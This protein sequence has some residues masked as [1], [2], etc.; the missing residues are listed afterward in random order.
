MNVED[1]IFKVA[2]GAPGFLLAVVCHEAAHAYVAY[3]YGDDTA[4]RQGRLTLNPVAHFDLIGTILFPLLGAMFS[5]FMFGW[6]KPVPINPARF[7]KVRQ[8]I[9]WVSFAGPGANIILG[10]VFSFILAI[11]YT[12][13]SAT[14]YLYTPLVEI[15]RNGVFINFILAFFNLIP[16][17]PLDGSKMVTSFLSY[18]NAMKYEGLARFSLLFLL[19]LMFTNILGYILAPA[20]MLGQ[21][22]IKI[23][24]YLLH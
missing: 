14:F 23:F 15:C 10:V 13:V 5:G 9:F 21:F 17:P 16:L 18:E 22:F 4:A 1:F 12:Q 7:K 6:A 2:V 20:F 11:L 8:G 19:V 24:V 3:R